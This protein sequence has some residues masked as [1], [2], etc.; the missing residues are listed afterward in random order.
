MSKIHQEI[1]FSATAANVYAA[2]ASSE[3]HAAFTGAPAA[4]GATAGSEFSAYGGKVSGR[5]IELVEGTRIVQAW[6]SADWPEGVYT[7]ATFQ[8][9]ADGDGTVLVFEQDAIPDGAVDHLDAG[10]HKMY[11]EP[12]RAYLEG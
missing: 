12:L 5:T 6:R 9:K 11:W 4:I 8:L 7:I 3:Q 1:N 2:L 10:W